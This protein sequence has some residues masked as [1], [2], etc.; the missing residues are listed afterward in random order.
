[1]SRRVLQKGSILKIVKNLPIILTDWTCFIHTPEDIKITLLIVNSDIISY[2][3]SYD[4]FS[5]C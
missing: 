2:D 4:M 1:M 3:M 5:L